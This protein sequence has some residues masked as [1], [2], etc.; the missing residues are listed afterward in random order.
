MQLRIKIKLIKV[1][2]NSYL[3]AMDNIIYEEIQKSDNLSITGNNIINKTCNYRQAL[4][5][6][7]YKKLSFFRTST[8]DK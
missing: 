6:K 2:T 8:Y 4:Y 7:H 3:L 1:C 5:W